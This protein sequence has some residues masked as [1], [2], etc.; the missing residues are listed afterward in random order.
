MS[1]NYVWILCIKWS[2]SANTTLLMIESNHGSKI[3]IYYNNGIIKLKKIYIAE[4]QDL[5]Q[6]ALEAQWL[7]N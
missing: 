5:V 6:H 1:H 3:C 2:Y 4:Q 7:Y